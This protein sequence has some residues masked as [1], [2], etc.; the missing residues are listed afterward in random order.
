MHLLAPERRGTGSRTSARCGSRLLGFRAV[1]VLCAVL[2]M[3]WMGRAEAGCTS[4]DLH[5]PVRNVLDDDGTGGRMSSLSSSIR[6]VYEGGTFRYEFTWGPDTGGSRPCN[7]PGC[8]GDRPAPG[9]SLT[10]LSQQTSR[11][12]SDTAGGVLPRVPQ[13]DLPGN[14]WMLA[15]PQPL[16]GYPVAAEYPP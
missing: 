5:L 16:D 11:S 13:V 1:L 3:C 12:I 7:G 2:P 10:P 4:H 6:W 8:R 14:L 15:E 9:S